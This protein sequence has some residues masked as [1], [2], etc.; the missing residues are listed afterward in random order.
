[1]ILRQKTECL[2]RSFHWSEGEPCFK[3]R[4]NITKQVCEYLSLG[5]PKL[6][7]SFGFGLPHFLSKLNMKLFSILQLLL[8]SVL[9]YMKL[10]QV[11]LKLYCYLPLIWAT[12]SVLVLCWKNCY[13]KNNRM[14]VKVKITPHFTSGPTVG[15]RLMER[16]DS[17]YV[18]TGTNIKGFLLFYNNQSK[19]TS[20][21]QTNK[22]KYCLRHQ[23]SADLPREI[24]Y[25]P[26]LH[27]TNT[28]EWYYICNTTIG[29][30]D[31]R[32]TPHGFHVRWLWTRWSFWPQFEQNEHFWG[33]EKR[34]CTTV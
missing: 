7:N 29:S 10:K 11:N 20:N 33:E 28:A 22:Q 27:Q 4:Q 31:L 34:S 19:E 9:Y 6:V 25:C 21:K 24:F 14:N 15:Y 13:L 26:R 32:H 1:M 18:K 30:D 8:Y 17:F 3:S 16:R 5:D 12:I 2:S 23:F